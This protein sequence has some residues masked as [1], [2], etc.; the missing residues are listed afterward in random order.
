[1]IWHDVVI[2]GKLFVADRAYSGLLPHLAVQKF[3]HFSRRPEFPI[4]SPATSAVSN[5]RILM[6]RVC[7]SRSAFSPEQASN[8]LY[9]GK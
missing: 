9:E 4:S 7:Q 2:V 5:A 1:M 8:L 6:K 3:S